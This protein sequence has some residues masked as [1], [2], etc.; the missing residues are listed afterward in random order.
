MTEP[1]PHHSVCMHTEHYYAVPRDS[2]VGRAFDC[3]SPMVYRM[4]PCS[5]Q[6]HESSFFFSL[7]APSA[8]GPTMRTSSFSLPRPPPLSLLIGWLAAR[9]ACRREGAHG[10]R[11]GHTAA[12]WWRPSRVLRRQPASCRCSRLPWRGHPAEERT[13]EEEGPAPTSLRLSRD[14]SN[15]TEQL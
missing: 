5:S 7:A 14:L 11:Q 1:F 8:S 12:A 6:G 2:S 3:R 15:G 9:A 13:S 4:V 10:H